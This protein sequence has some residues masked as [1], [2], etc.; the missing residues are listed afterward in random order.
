M[1]L[2]LVAA[3]SLMALGLS[4]CQPQTTEQVSDTSTTDVAATD[5]SAAT[6]MSVDQRQAYA[7]GA[8]M[9]TY[10]TNRATESEKYGLTIDREALQQGFEDALAGNS[11]F[12]V[13]E[14]QSIA[15]EAD[16]RLQQKQQEAAQNAAQDNIEIGK[17]FLAENGKKEGVIT[18]ESG[19]QYEV[20]AEG[21]GASPTAEDTVT[22]HYR[23]TLLDGTEFDSSYKRNEPASFPLS[24][25]IAGW[26][27]GVQLMKEGAK[28]RFYIPSEL[29]YGQRSTGSITPNSTLIFDVE[30]IEVAKADGE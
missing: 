9:G 14:M 15:R 26:T 29:A 10:V 5:A 21:E 11:K 24:R 2:S 27:E 28:Y 7:L 19:L 3:T 30:L 13:E 17:Q 18:T 12:T 22:V 8:S 1:R 25:V 16:A 23:G 6:E 4:A 20:L